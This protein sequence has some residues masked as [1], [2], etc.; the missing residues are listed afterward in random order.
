M[1]LRFG[2]RCER[3]LVGGFGPQNEARRPDTA[4]RDAITADRRPLRRREIGHYACVAVGDEEG[5]SARS[6]YQLRVIHPHTGAHLVG[7][8]GDL[9]AALIAGTPSSSSVFIKVTLQ[10]VDLRTDSIVATM[11]VTPD[12]AS[13][14][15]QSI[16]KDLDRLNPTAFAEEWGIKAG[17]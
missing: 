3:H 17:A 4:P 7:E 2:V 15:T 1:G 6:R 12:V 5:K 16:G 8:L 9:L 11:R 10:V 14:L 13:E